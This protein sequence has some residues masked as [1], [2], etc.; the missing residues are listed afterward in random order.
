MLATVGPIFKS[1]TKQALQFRVTNANPGK[2]TVILF[3]NGGRATL[4]D[5]RVSS[6]QNGILTAYVALS[7]WGT[8]K[9]Q[10]FN[11]NGNRTSI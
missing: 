5:A 11:E 10:V 4:M 3:P 2:R 6:L 7:A 8:F 1:N 9:I